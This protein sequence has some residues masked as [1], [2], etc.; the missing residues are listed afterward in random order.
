MFVNNQ[1]RTHIYMGFTWRRYSIGILVIGITAVGMV[2]VGVGYVND[3][4]ALR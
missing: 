2:V 1:V 3:L 4:W